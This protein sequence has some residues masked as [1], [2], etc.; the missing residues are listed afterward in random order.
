V[1]P[2]RQDEHETL[3]TL[4]KNVD[5]SFAYDLIKQCFHDSGPGRPPR[6]PSGI[7]RAFLI[8]RMKA[9]RS[10]RE[11]TRILNSDQRIRKLC[12]IKDNQKGYTRS[13]MSRFSKRVGQD[14]LN[15]IIDQKVIK[16]LKSQQPNEVDVVLDASFIKAWSTRH[17]TDNQI[18]FSDAQ[19]RVGRSG[20][21]YALGYKMHLSIDHKTMLPLSSVF[22]SSNQNEKKHSLTL[23]EK[24]KGVLKRC[25]AKVR[26]VVAD[27][28]YSDSKLRCAVEKAT[29]PYP[30]NHRKGVEGL[31]RVDRKFRTYGSLEDK[32]EYHKRPPI[33]AV[34]SFLKTQFSLANNK[35]RGLAQVT[36]YALCSILCLVL[37]REA[38]QKIGR[39][40]KA[41]SPTYFNT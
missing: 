30:A 14:N 23:L 18:G 24:A 31:L 13:V 12:L 8:M 27:S 1:I 38:A 34:N 9:I 37:N 40:E 11:M 32:T 16:L 41:V 6:N 29:I 36:F 4:F 17:P 21:S 15:K 39:D 28:Q 2:A 25:K 26:S 5:L 20:R 35:V 19:A 33:E 3:E 22:V 7:F 10:L